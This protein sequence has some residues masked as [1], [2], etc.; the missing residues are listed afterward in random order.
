MIPNFLQPCCISDL[1]KQHIRHSE[2]EVTVHKLNENGDYNL[3]FNGHQFKLNPDCI[4]EL[5]YKG[6]N[7]HTY[8]CHTHCLLIGTSG[9][10]CKKNNKKEAQETCKC[11]DRPGI[12]GDRSYQRK[13]QSEKKQKS[14]RGNKKNTKKKYNNDYKNIKT[15]NYGEN[16]YQNQNENQATEPNPK[17]V[18]NIR[19]AADTSCYK[20]SAY[21]ID[22]YNWACHFW[23]YRAGLQSGGCRGENNC[24]LTADDGAEISLCQ[25]PFGNQCI[26]ACLKISKYPARCENNKCMCHLD[27]DCK[28]YILKFIRVLQS[29]PDNENVYGLCTDGIGDGECN[30][31]CSITEEHVHAQDKKCVCGGCTNEKVQRTKEIEKNIEEICRS[32]ERKSIDCKLKCLQLHFT[33]GECRKNGGTTFCSCKRLDDKWR[34]LKERD[35]YTKDNKEKDTD[36]W[37]EDRINKNCEDSYCDSACFLKHQFGGKCFK[38]QCKCQIKRAEESWTKYEEIVTRIVHEDTTVLENYPREPTDLIERCT[39]ERDKIDCKIKCRGLKRDDG[40]CNKNECVCQSTDKTW[41]SYNELYKEYHERE[42][43]HH[44][45]CRMDHGEGDCNY[46]CRGVGSSAGRCN[47]GICQCL[48]ETQT[49]V[50]LDETIEQ[51]YRY[52]ICDKTQ[53]D[54]LCFNYCRRLRNTAGSCNMGYCTCDHEETR[55]PLEETDICEN[56]IAGDKL[57]DYECKKV[58]YDRGQCI[59]V[60]NGIRECKCIKSGAQEWSKFQELI[61]REYY[62]GEQYWGE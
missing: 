52:N 41:K 57:C 40:I 3:G 2:L 19:I 7:F 46:K 61:R 25:G 50:E 43:W 53:N 34:K 12:Y 47:S 51:T 42:I 6:L 26:E 31:R 55:W 21:G 23:C 60:T 5:R 29:P 54:H 36:L 38:S 45:V 16:P 33:D 9:G 18:N 59:E 30:Y 28:W 37:F 11:D 39:T 44:Q 24:K 15:T 56:K 62:S 35:Y 4:E 13:I 8:H 22:Y 49:W 1:D 27:E 10:R 17:I 48:Y 32:E 20:Q 14:I 58:M